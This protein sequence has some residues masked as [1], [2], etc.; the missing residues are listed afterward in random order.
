MS[1]TK[2]DI[3]DL[4]AKQVDISHSQ[5][6]SVTNDFFDTIKATLAKGEDV[7]LSGFGNFIV[8]SKVARPGRNPKTGDPVTISARTVATFKAGVKLKRITQQG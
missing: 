5:A 3:A 4:L 1:I 2:K 8:R 6:L 7:K